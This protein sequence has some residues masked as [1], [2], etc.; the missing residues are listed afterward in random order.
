MG[1]PLRTTNSF[2]HELRTTNNEQQKNTSR[3]PTSPAE[4]RVSLSSC[5]LSHHQVT[6]FGISDSHDFARR[7][8]PLLTMHYVYITFQAGRLTRSAPT[9]YE[10]RTT[11]NK[12]ST[13]IFQCFFTRISGFLSSQ[14][15][16]PQ[17]LSAFAGLTAV[18]G[19]G[20]GGSPQLSPLNYIVQDSYPDNCI[21]MFFLTNSL[22]VSES[23]FSLCI[24]FQFHSFLRFGV[25]DSLSFARRLRLLQNWFSA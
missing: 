23:S 14:G 22:L 13:G 6:R 12:K 25:S 11:N 20:T 1:R 21:K 8:A 17:V 5:I 7:K 9:S 24:C 4:S 15:A 18:F 16:S 10:P 3:R 19:M 2:P